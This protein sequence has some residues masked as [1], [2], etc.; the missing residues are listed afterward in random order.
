LIY[1][2]TRIF[3]GIKYTH[4]KAT[5]RAVSGELN[6][7]SVLI[8]V[9]AVFLICHIPG[10]ILNCTE[11]FLVDEIIECPD[12][13]IPANWNL[14]LASLNHALLIVNA[15]INFIIYTSVGDSFKKSLKKLVQRVRVGSNMM[16]NVNPTITKD[17]DS[18][19]ANCEGNQQAENEIFTTCV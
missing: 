17:I 12:H 15:S 13:F 16:L 1:F 18:N 7:A 5:N 8:C 4:Q 9:V 11:F 3:R 6:L 10:V 19:I 2:N 14:C